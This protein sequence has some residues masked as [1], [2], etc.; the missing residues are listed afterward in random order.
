[1]PRPR[2]APG[3]LSRIRPAAED[4]FARDGPGLAG[5]ARAGLDGPA[6]A[7]LAGT[8]RGWPGTG[9][10]EPGGGSAACGL[11]WRPAARSDQRN[12]ATSRA[13]RVARNI[14]PIMASST[15]IAR[16]P[17]PAAVKSPY[18]R[19]VSVVKLKYWNVLVVSSLAPW[20]KNGG[21]GLNFHIAT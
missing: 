18:P 16:P 9:W 4:F 10:P 1:M 15:A 14:W 6:P 7:G 2:T 3:G 21:W 19:V 8:A 17:S 13:T 12:P 11:V 5:T 20:A